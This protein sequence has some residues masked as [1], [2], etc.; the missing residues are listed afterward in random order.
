M[1]NCNYFTFKFDV[2]V[3][4]K[5]NWSGHGKDLAYGEFFGDS[6]IAEFLCPKCFET[7]AFVQFPMKEE[8]KNGKQ[9]TQEKKRVGKNKIYGHRSTE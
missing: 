5:C 6:Y 7:I 1:K 8:V 9:K 4:P 3:C 2:I